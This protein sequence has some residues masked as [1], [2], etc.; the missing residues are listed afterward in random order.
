M[1]RK[2]LSTMDP[3]ESVREKDH[4][5]RTRALAGD[6]TVLLKNDGILPLSPMDHPKI[7]LYGE[8]ARNTVRGG[9]GSGMTITRRDYSVEDA[10]E[11]AGFIV[12]TKDWLSRQ[13][14]LRKAEFDAFIRSMQTDV[15]RHEWGY[16]GMIMTDWFMTETGI[17]VFSAVDRE[18]PLR[19]GNTVSEQCVS[20][21]ND[22]IMPGS[23]HD[24]EDII[25][26]VKEGK[27][28]LA[29]LQRCALHVLGLILHSDVYEDARS[30]YH[31]V[32]VTEP[33]VTVER[34]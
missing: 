4:F 31:W 19:Y 17:D 33:E 22:I 23:T 29:D 21:G 12:T 13:D 15:C 8:G 2:F 30:W 20:A 14:A 28:A 3:R 32:K 7:A 6:C 5:R 27:V 25:R 24:R 34:G 11:A 10:L 1:K 18:K 26:A 9:T 16:Q